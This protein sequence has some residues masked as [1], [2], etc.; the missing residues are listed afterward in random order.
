[1]EKSEIS[2]H[3]I[4]VCDALKKSGNWMTN[5]EIAKQAEISDRTVRA[6]TLKLVKLGL[7]DQAEVFPAHRYRWSEKAEK[8]NAGYWVRLKM[9]ANVFNMAI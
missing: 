7:L 2:I 4:K 3:E 8:R 9:A 5:K 6:H 1:M